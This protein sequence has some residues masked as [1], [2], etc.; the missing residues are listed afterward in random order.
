VLGGILTAVR[1]AAEE[2]RD[3]A[4]VLGCDMPFVP[5]SLL[6]RIVEEA[7]RE[8]VVLPASEGPRGFEPL[9]AAYGVMTG[10]AI[11]RALDAGERAIIS[12]FE[13]VPVHILDFD[14]VLG[15]GDPDRMFLNVNR[16]EDRERAERIATG[17]PGNTGHGKQP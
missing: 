4:L 8:S 7:D 17:S 5:S 12:F 13:H 15:F 9:C 3:T 2:G 6:I 14:T 10:E 1:W 11:G 16:P